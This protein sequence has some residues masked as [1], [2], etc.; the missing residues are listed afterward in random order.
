M[1]L[2]FPANSSEITLEEAIVLMKRRTRKFVRRQAN[3]FK[4][5]DPNIHWFENNENA[6]D[7]ISSFIQSNQDWMK[8]E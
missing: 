6:I 5:S 3:W 8:I 7:Q 2:S 1:R 4:P